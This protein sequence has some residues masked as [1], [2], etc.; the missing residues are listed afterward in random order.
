MESTGLSDPELEIELV[1]RNAETSYTI[2]LGNALPA[3][4]ESSPALDVGDP[5]MEKA[6]APPRYGAIGGLTAMKGENG[7][8]LGAVLSSNT[9]AAIVAQA[10]LI[11]GVSE[12]R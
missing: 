8:A 4:G 3:A 2:R 11:A 5:T 9:A 1:Q 10:R 12:T 7:P 6:E